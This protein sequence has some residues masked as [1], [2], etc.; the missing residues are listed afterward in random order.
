M[1]RGSAE[2]ADRRDE[3]HFLAIQT[4]PPVPHAQRRL[5]PQ[6]IHKRTE[7]PVQGGK[8]DLD[9]AQIQSLGQNKELLVHEFFK[10]ELVRLRADLG[11]RVVFSQAVN[12]ASP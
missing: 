5:G 4:Q 3:K 6:R 8:L 11:L 1:M 9:A 2:N 10:D 7:K 12:N